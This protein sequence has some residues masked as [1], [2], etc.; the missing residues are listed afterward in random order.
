MVRIVIKCRVPSGMWGFQKEKLIRSS[1]SCG[2]CRTTTAG[3]LRDSEV[4]GDFGDVRSTKYGGRGGWQR[5][6]RARW[7]AQRYP[8]K[9]VED[10]RRKQKS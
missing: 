1:K 7:G 9:G 5:T 6:K 8:R 4:T 10:G 3:G 2:P